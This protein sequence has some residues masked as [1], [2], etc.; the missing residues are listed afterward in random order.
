MDVP[1]LAGSAAAQ[2]EYELLKVL[3]E[4]YFGSMMVTDEKGR[5][6]YVNDGCCKLLGIDRETLLRI[7][8]YDTLHDYCHAS[9]AS[10]IKTLETRRECLSNHTLEASGKQVLALS[11][12]LIHILQLEVT[13]PTISPTPWVT[14]ELNAFWHSVGSPWS[15]ALTT[16]SVVPSTPPAAL[17]SSTA[18]FTP[19]KM[20]EP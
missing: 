17:I 18:R 1:D 4:H 5:C 14:R 6:L 7:S 15:S 8:I 19:F 9:S 2:R 12:S 10:S 13:E 16:S 20:A 11:L 3:A